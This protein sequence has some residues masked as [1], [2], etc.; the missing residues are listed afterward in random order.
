[1]SKST[2][3][4]HWQAEPCGT[5]GHATGENEGEGEGEAGL[6]F[7]R[8]ERDRYAAEPHIPGFARFASARGL[9]VLEVGV[10]AGT[11]F[12]QWARA[13]ARATGVDLTPAAVA[14]TRRRL[15]QEGLPGHVV[16]ADA[17]AL[18]FAEASFDIVYSYGVLHHTPDVR[19]AIAEVHRVLKP[20]GVARLMLYG[21]PSWTGWMLWA[22]HGAARGQPWRSPKQIIAEHLES[23]G[24]Q[25]FAETEA[26]QLLAAFE[27]V[28]IDRA[29]LAGD[30]LLQP[31][32]QRYRSAWH[33]WA[34]ALY[35]R[36]WVRA[37]GQRFGFGLLIEAI[38]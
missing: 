33:A 5:R 20:G 37:F 14:L 2:V 27:R 8:I 3:A 7:D 34:W 11:D 16:Q 15:E 9:E 36:G 1:M 29:L 31:P 17:E 25:A 28:Q 10:G 22:V 6:D 35:P 4:E 30:L 24:T 13:G 19:A 21:L 38:K 12:V 23:P 26:R 18:P 32:S